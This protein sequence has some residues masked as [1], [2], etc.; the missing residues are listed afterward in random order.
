MLV[1]E[2]ALTP[3]VAGQFHARFGDRV[4]ILHS[5]FNDTERARAVAAA[6]RGR[7]D[8]GGGDALGRVRAGARTWA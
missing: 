1:P 6:A 3:A 2:I 5:A 4:A 8:G 7:G